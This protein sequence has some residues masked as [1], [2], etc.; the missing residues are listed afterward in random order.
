VAC[1]SPEVP[2]PLG[3]EPTRVPDSLRA[4]TIARLIAFGASARSF[5]SILRLRPFDGTTAEGRSNERYRRAALTTVVSIVARGLGIFT[6]LAWI[7]LSL[8]YLGREQYGLWMAINS[9]VGWANLADLGLARGLQ[10]H[11]SAA[12]GKDDRDL[13]GRYVS[14]GLAALTTLAI[15]VAVLAVPL[16]VVVPWAGALNVRDPALASETPWVLSAVL[17]SFLVQFP[18]SIVPTIFAAYQRGYVEGL[19]NIAGSLLSLGALIAVTRLQLSLP[20]LVVCTSGT[21]ILML[22]VAFG[23]AVRDMPWLRPRISF[24]SI[25]TLR[26]LGATSAALFFFQIGALMIGETQSIIL[27]RRLGLASVAEWSVL[28]RVHLLPSIF[29]Q[30]V[31]APLIPAFREAHV[32]G[33]HEWL[34]TAFWRVTKLKMVIGI[35]A[36]GLYVV[37][38]NLAAKI[39]SGQDFA[40]SPSI[41]VACGFLLLVT[42][43]NQSFN[44][45]MIAVDRLRLLVITVFFN[46][47]VTPAIGYLLAPSHG[48]LGM[49]VA[50]PI[51]SLVV[52][53]W[54]L[55][56]ACRDIIRDRRNPPP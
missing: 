7:R 5:K 55:P 29:I 34:R 28:L 45:L 12:N 14:T 22:L 44:D 48:L 3:V 25:K 40:F 11:L 56:L 26:A 52:S 6:G 41:W 8:T 53:A 31:D 38:G 27:A 17:G 2:P 46:G 24:V 51:F 42:V 4:R 36:A 13:A 43:W 35:V 10:N 54:L 37:F 49:L 16:L 23:A 33:E 47:L 21:G 15:V 9:I 20:L 1:P 19:F 30:M 39:I 18:L 32:R 50:M